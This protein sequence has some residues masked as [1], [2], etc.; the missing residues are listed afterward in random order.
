MSGNLVFLA[1]NRAL[2]LIRDGGLGPDLVRVIAGAAG[3]PKWL[4]LSHLDRAVFGTWL[5]RRDEPLFLLGS[6]IGAWRFAAAC[7]TN[8]LAAIEQFEH[9]YIHQSYSLAPTPDEVTRETWRIQKAILTE[10]AVREILDHRFLRLNVLAVR[11][12]RLLGRDDRYLLGFGLGLAALVNL[13]SRRGLKL[14]FERSL[15]SDPRDVPPF[16]NMS[17]FPIQKTP[18]GADNIRPALVASGSIPLVMRGVAGVPGAR[19]GVY[20]DGALIDYH[21]DLPLLNDGNGIALYPHFS[22]RLIPG[23]FDKKLPWRRPSPANL[24]HALLV[25]PS[26]DFMEKL[27]LGRLPDREDFQT[28]KGRDR[29]RI[30]YWSTIV[31]LC[32]RLGDEFLETTATGRIREVVRPLFP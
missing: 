18:L 7:R 17:G 30:F 14:F 15:F 29:E 21:L 6:S 24:D 5:T 9:E 27:P 23:W 8:P 16:F 22:E 1:G 19:P 4:V 20:R 31:E 2:S 12:R 11:C 25:A 32:E 28:F 13:I 3:G 10:E 26:R